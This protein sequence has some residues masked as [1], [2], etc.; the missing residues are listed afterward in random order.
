MY[1]NVCVCVYFIKQSMKSLNSWVEWN[2]FRNIA[3]TVLISNMET[4]NGENNILYTILEI[5]ISG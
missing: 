3:C 1:I 5:D 4:V 2:D